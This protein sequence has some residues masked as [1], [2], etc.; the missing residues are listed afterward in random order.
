MKHMRTWSNLS[1]SPEQCRNKQNN[2]NDLRNEQRLAD[3]HGEQA[4]TAIC[5]VRLLL[6]CTRARTSTLDLLAL[7]LRRRRHATKRLELFERIR[8]FLIS[9]ERRKCPG[10]LLELVRTPLPIPSKLHAH[11]DTS[12]HVL[13]TSLIINSKL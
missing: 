2:K 9:F 4:N 11:L 13:L 12:I 1:A 7:R 3:C 8:A 5:Y 10:S 6:R